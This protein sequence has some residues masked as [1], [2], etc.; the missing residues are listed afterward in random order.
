MFPL[1]K[2]KSFLIKTRDPKVSFGF[3]G[4]CNLCTHSWLCLFCNSNCMKLPFPD[5]FDEL[6]FLY[7][8][9]FSPKFVSSSHYRTNTHLVAVLKTLFP[10]QYFVAPCHKNHDDSIECLHYDNLFH[11]MFSTEIMP[12]HFF[13]KVIYDILW[14]LHFIVEILF[15]MISV[16]IWV[17]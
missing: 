17:F 7:A 5:V 4:H 11:H 13:L 12:R 6:L 2:Q 3:G 8:S 14:C 1:E 9:L 10:S 15:I 16:M